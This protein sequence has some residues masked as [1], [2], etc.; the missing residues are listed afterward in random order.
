LDQ[1]IG[2]TIIEAL[3]WKIENRPITCIRLLDGTFDVPSPDDIQK[4]HHL[5]TRKVL[6]SAGIEV[7]NAKTTMIAIRAGGI[8]G[9]HIGARHLQKQ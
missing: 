5:C 6:S 7:R 2:S 9:S 3:Y 8:I 1:R 4:P